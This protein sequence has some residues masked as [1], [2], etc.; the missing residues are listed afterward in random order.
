MNKKDLIKDL[1]QLFRDR[2]PLEVNRR[3]IDIPVNTGK[4]ITLCGG[5]RCG[6]TY[7]LFDIINKLK[8]LNVQSEN[9]F[10]L[11]FDDDRLSFKPDELDLIIQ[12]FR[13]LNPE[14]SLK[15]SYFFFDEIQMTDGWEQ[16]IRR[17]YDQETKNIF[18]TGSNSRLLATDIAT[19]LRGRTLTYEVF[20]LSFNEYCSFRSISK[21]VYYTP[22]RTK[23][24]LEFKKYNLSGAYPELVLSDYANADHLLQD[25][26]L[27]M[28]FKDVVERYGIRNIPVLK[29]FI[30]RLLTNLTKPTSINKIY[31]EVRSAGLKCDKNLLYNLVYQLESI[32]FSFR[33]GRYDLS[34]LKTELALDKKIYFIDNGLVNALTSGYKNELGKL[35][36]NN[37][38]M[39]LRREH[40]FQR[41]CHYFKGKNEC[42]FVTFDREKPLK[43]IQACW[44]LSDGNTLKREIAGL[45]EAAKHLECDDLNIITAEEEKE[46]EQD[47]FIVKVTPAWKEMLKV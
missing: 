12:S 29:Y 25:Y 36:E 34:I 46:I 19:S 32:F 22:A 21:E 28:L 26:Y 31:N 45:V 13:E 5:R 11:S 37:V 30:S 15:E 6:K 3:D 47:N 41:G 8:S 24:L 27:L 35:L 18:I 44:D 40:L 7:L 43:L 17:I 23:L 16:F 20:P 14:V 39:W 4:I 33:L 42:D 9:I 10:F 1:I 38:F 2:L